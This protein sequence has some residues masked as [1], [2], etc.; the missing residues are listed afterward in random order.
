[1]HRERISLDHNVIEEPPNE[2]M[3]AVEKKASR[4]GF[5]SPKD[6][7]SYLTKQ[8]EILETETDSSAKK[9]GL[10]FL[11]TVDSIR[12]L[13]IAFGKDIPNQQDAIAGSYGGTR[14]MFTADALANNPK[15]L[16]ELWD[17]IYFPLMLASGKTHSEAEI[18]ASSFMAELAVGKSINKILTDYGRNDLTVFKSS[19]AEDALKGV[20]LFITNQDKKTDLPLQVKLYRSHGDTFVRFISQDINDIILY[21]KDYNE[22]ENLFN[23]RSGAP[24]AELTKAIKAALPIKPQG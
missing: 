16:N 3:A 12:R 20:D 2:L 19:V 17:G 6:Y 24:S 22:L 8:K 1:M 23:Q 13:S 9:A 11:E 15:L 10:N 5:Y 14:L 7:N 4:L 18:L 21:Y